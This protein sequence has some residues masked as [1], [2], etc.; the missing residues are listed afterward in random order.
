MSLENVGKSLEK[1]HFPHKTSTL[2]ISF[3][4]FFKASFRN[5]K[6]LHERFF[7]YRCFFLNFPFISVK[8]QFFTSWP[9]WLNDLITIAKYT[10]TITVPQHLL[11]KFKKCS[12]L[13]RFFS[14]FE[15]DFKGRDFQTL[16]FLNFRMYSWLLEFS[17]CQKCP[18]RV[19]FDEI[20][21]RNGDSIWT[22][23]CVAKGVEK[24]KFWIPL[25]WTFFILKET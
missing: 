24:Q 7:I 12:D 22:L 14:V 6:L 18:A 15:I 5:S 25:K 11:F 9:R 20:F 4:Q 2:S 1:K 23:N 17:E 21:S 19:W 13:C 3:I 8:K 10:E 16:F